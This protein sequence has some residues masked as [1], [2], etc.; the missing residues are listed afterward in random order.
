MQLWILCPRVDKSWCLKSLFVMGLYNDPGVIMGEKRFSNNNKRSIQIHQW[1]ACFK[2]KAR[3][4]HWGMLIAETQDPKELTKKEKGREREG[5]R[6]REGAG[7]ERETE[8]RPVLCMIK[9]WWRLIDYS[10]RQATGTLNTLIQVK[11]VPACPDWVSL[12]WLEGLNQGTTTHKKQKYRKS[13]TQ[14]PHRRP[15]PRGGTT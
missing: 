3:M 12:R 6:E 9:K 1:G 14:P 10:K 13:T 11:L 5:K 7:E 15:L 2:E 8:E 4:W